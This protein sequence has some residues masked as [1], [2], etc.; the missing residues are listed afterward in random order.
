MKDIM[1]RRD[2]KGQGMV[3][4]AIVFPLL[5][6]LLFGIFEFSRVMFAY[7]VAVSSSREAARYG[8][9]I[10]DIGGG[11]PQYE[12]CTGIRDAAKRIGR[13]AGI[14]DAGIT[15]QYSNDSGI[16]ST[17]C[18]PSQE[19]NSGDTISVTIDTSIAPVTFFGNLS[20]I[21]INSSS[22]RTILKNVELGFPG[23]GVGSISG[24]LSDVNFKSTHQSVE[25][26]VGTISV[27][28]E[29]NQVATDLVT[30]P[31]SVTGNALEGAGQDY[32]MTS[33][34]VTINPGD[35]TA[36]LYINLNNDGVTEGNELL[37]IGIDTPTNATKGPQSIHTITI[38][39][40]PDVLFSNISSVT[41]E[42]TTTIALTVELSKGSSQD[43][44]VSISTSGTAVWGATSDYTTYPDPIVIP[45]G[46]LS[47]IL[48]V[49][50][51]N[52]T[53]DE[54]D[55]TAVLTLVNPTNALLGSTPIHTIT[56]LDDDVPPM[57]SFFGPN[58][59]VS[60]EIGI[61]TTSLRLSEVSGKNI[62]VEYTTSG[63]TVPEDYIIHN[64]SPLVIPVGSST[65]D[66]NMDILENDGWEVDETLILTLGSPVNASLGSPATQTI[67]ITEQS[68]APDVFF[69]I[70]SQT[71]VEG[72]L[73]LDVYVQMSNA[74]ES[75][76]VI[77]YDLSGTAERG[78][79]QDYQI[80]PEPLVIP[81]GWTVGA[82]QVQILDD[83]TDESDEYFSITLGEITNGSPGSPTVHTINI[84][85]DE[86]PPELN[87]AL[88]YRSVVEDTGTVL[89]TVTL[90]SLSVEDI[91]VPLIISGSAS[92]G[93]DY[94]IST[95]NVVIPAGSASENF[96]ITITDDPD[97]EP[98]ESIVV[99]LGVPV[100]GELGTDTE[101]VVDIDDN[102]LSPCEVGSHLLTV[103]ADSLS[104]SMVNEGNDL[105]LTGGSVTWPEASSTQP[106]LTEIDFDGAV[107]FSGSVKPTNYSFFAWEAYSSLA[108]ES[109]SYQFDSSLGTGEYT[110][111]SNFQNPDNGIT[112]SLTET[113]TNH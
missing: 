2:S 41:A 44:S 4:F 81:I 36:T 54:E 108:T 76:V 84:N 113:Y 59:V 8:A 80:T 102:D 104:L 66:I 57:I 20:P 67:I 15:I 109:V 5:L 82:L 10:Q 99:D 27:V 16:Y 13:Y 29:L 89:G 93:N 11:I 26:T 34:P 60:E 7:S 73:L 55:E 9:A 42:S 94:T 86:S 111:V 88:G 25:E 6:M 19:V 107:I 62:S 45:S 47:T 79:M 91:S 1:K 50:I 30:I 69:S 53:I 37:V 3:E 83:D 103:G 38:S 110:I 72:N 48:V 52:D 39:D 105:V 77:A 112:C 56:I 22:S 100:N 40:P 70:S 17:V 33:S 23:T 21:P 65:V 106:R 71:V 90:S 35:K 95:T 68:F 63:T 64:P 28:L 32:L 18:P 49:T 101:F 31:F 98:S 14:S 74:W 12:D 24:A 97:Y 92:L 96:V 78:A 51:N 61:F 87:F 85:D 58:Q 75:E 43:V 46:S